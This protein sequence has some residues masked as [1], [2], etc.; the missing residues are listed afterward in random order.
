MA[1]QEFLS[2]ESF[3]TTAKYLSMA[4]AVAKQLKL[5]YKDHTCIIEILLQ[6]YQVES[7]R[8]KWTLI[9]EALQKQAPVESCGDGCGCA[10]KG[11]DFNILD[12]DDE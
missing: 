1:E 2:Q 12:D 9:S 3:V 10:S 7:M 8:D 5:N 6:V 4:Q 11:N